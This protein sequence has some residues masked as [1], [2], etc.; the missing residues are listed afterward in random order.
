VTVIAWW[1]PFGWLHVALLLLNSLHAYNIFVITTL[2]SSTNNGLLK[3]ISLI[4]FVI[5]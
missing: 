1:N 3:T 4:F 5:E 2:I